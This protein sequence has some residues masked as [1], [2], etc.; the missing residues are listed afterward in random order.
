[1]SIYRVSVCDTNR[2]TFEVE[3]SDEDAACSIATEHFFA[4]SDEWRNQHYDDGDF[5]VEDVRRG[6]ERI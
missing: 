3:A 6:Q 2:Y 1:M 4:Q 5:E